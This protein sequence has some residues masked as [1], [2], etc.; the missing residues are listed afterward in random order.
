MTRITKRDMWAFL[1]GMWFTTLVVLAIEA[2]S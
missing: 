1:A 2:L